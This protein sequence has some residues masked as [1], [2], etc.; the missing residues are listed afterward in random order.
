MYTQEEFYNLLD[1]L[2]KKNKQI[3]LSSD[4]PPS[5]L[6]VLDEKIGIGFEHGMIADISLPNYKTRLS[7]LRAKLKELKIKLPEYV[8]EYVASDIDVQK[9]VRDLEADLERL[10]FYYKKHE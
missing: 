4:R 1:Y 2:Y 7:I 10:L 5:D 9:N 3:I 8:L 6:Q